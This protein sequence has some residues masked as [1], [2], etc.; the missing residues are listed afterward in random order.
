MK[1]WV[2]KFIDQ[3]ET[4]GSNRQEYTTEQ[5]EI[6]EE[7]A[8]VLFVMDTLS[9]YL[10][11]FESYPT[12]KARGQIDEMAQEI[13]KQNPQTLEKAFFRFRQFYSSYRVNEYTYIQ[14]TFDDFRNI[15]WDFV[16]QLHGDYEADACEAELK[17]H[18]NDLKEAVEANSIDDLKSTSRQFI[19]TYI[20]YQ[21][22][23]DKRKSE[24][25]R[26]FQKNLKTIKKQLNEAQLS[27][28]LDHLTKA[29]NR[30]SF[31]EHIQ[32]HMQLSQVSGD[33]ACLV[34]LDIDHFKKVNDNYGHQTGDAILIECVKLLKESFGRDQDFV[35]RV[36]GEEFAVV[37]SDTNVSAAID[38]VEAA[39][40]KIR[41]TVY[42]EDNHKI[43]FT[44][45][46][47]IAQLKKNEN[48]D[49]WLKRADEALYH[50]KNTGRDR[51]TVSGAEKIGKVS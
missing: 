41:E 48:V 6:N 27:M 7:Q 22:N 8:T 37:M 25:I 2:K 29:Y 34:M 51:Y 10:L 9:K 21:F 36:G 24:N 12:R 15:I 50:S 1:R 43:Q 26:V 38:I 23:K 28:R 40:D 46:V 17:Q 14:K 33:P 49:E 16:E 11:D 30:K 19:D 44:I 4:E 35:A 13:I 18:F 42:V 32:K 20:E 47:G 3:F 5:K 39:M 31:D 45:S